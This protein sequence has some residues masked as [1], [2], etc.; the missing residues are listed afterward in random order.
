LAPKKGEITMATTAS[1]RCSAKC[2]QC[3]TTLI[4][5]EWSESLGDHETIHI[6]HCP[7]CGH[8]FETT[9]DVIEQKPSDAEVI[10]ECLPSLLVA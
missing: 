8:E 10:E 9:D 6:W 3:G 5:P 4:F 1:L 2:I 7:I